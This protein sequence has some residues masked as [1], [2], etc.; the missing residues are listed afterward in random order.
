MGQADIKRDEISSAQPTQKKYK[1]IRLCVGLTDANYVK[2]NYV[3]L[4]HTKN[5]NYKKN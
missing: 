4:A 1:K 2:K 3:G 5:G